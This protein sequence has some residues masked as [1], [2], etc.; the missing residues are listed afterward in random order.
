MPEWGCLLINQAGFT[1]LN[2]EN[3]L[4][5]S[6][7]QTSAIILETHLKWKDERGPAK[8][9]GK[10]GYA[11]KGTGAP[12]AP[13]STRRGGEARAV[14]G[15]LAGD[16]C[17]HSSLSPGEQALGGLCSQQEVACAALR[18]DRYER[19]TN[20]ERR[21]ISLAPGRLCLITVMLPEPSGTE[22]SRRLFKWESSDK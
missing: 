8:A 16:R 20:K 4:E 11:R 6:T 5:S 2:F 17:Q 22:W 12:S 9:E 19:I 10:R 14:S 21:S 3:Q 18:G 13:P 1:E 7:R 15:T